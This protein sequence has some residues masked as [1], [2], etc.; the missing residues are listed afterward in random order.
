MYNID[1]ENS[2]I[3]FEVN[4]T[5][6]A[7]K[8]KSGAGGGGTG[9][10]VYL[11]Q[12]GDFTMPTDKNTYSALRI[13]AEITK[14][15]I[16]KNND[17]TANGL[18]TFIKG[19]KSDGIIKVG[20]AVDSFLAGSGIIMTPDGRIQADKL[21]ARYAAIFREV[22]FNRLSAQ[23]GDAAYSDNGLIESLTLEIDGTYTLHLRKRWDN[24]FTSFH[25]NDIL[26]GDVNELVSGGA[27]YTSWVRV[28]SVNVANNSISVVVYPDSE[29]PGG[30]N[31]IPV[32]LMK[33][34]RRGNAVNTERQS[35]W[36]LSATTDKCFIWLEGVN[37]PIIEESNYY[38]MLGRPRNISLFDNLPLNYNQAAIFA[39]AGIF[40]NLFRV[41]VTGNPVVDVLPGVPWVTG[42]AYTSS[43]TQAQTVYH[44][45]CRYQCIVPS[46]TQEPK[47]GATDW[48]MIEG[49][50][51]FT[52]DIES[53][54]GW[55]FEPSILQTTLSVQGKLYNQDVTDN[56][57]DADISWTRDSGNITEDNAWAVTRANAGKNLPITVND[58][59]P[60][61]MQQTGCKFKATA[62]LRD[63]V[64]SEAIVTIQ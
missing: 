23:E 46:T 49:N 44:Y 24:D 2:D 51:E 12:V 39:R 26:F 25:E 54:E 33:L 43:S 5:S 37:K 38:M 13:I 30:I 11:I 59:G 7:F 35:Y 52:I 48:A 9:S 17:D 27:F 32:E 1:E 3:S 8:V 20:D 28:L 19:L 41:D 40:Q 53:S 16:S 58:L 21:E 56:L 31:N 4:G 15:A 57:L 50:P 10:S 47:Y 6:V 60:N 55:Y 63:G 22:I 64:S 36:Y 14:Y 62:L 42:T 29:V 45:G 18:I 34:V 61:Y